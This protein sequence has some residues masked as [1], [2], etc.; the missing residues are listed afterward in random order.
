MELDIV[1]PRKRP[2]WDVLLLRSG[3]SSFFHTA[4]WAGVLSDTYGYK[5]LYFA[6]FDGGR[7]SGLMAFMEIRSSLTGRRG[8]SLP[9]SDHCPAYFAS[10]DHFQEVANRALDY[11]RNAG[12]R[13]IEWR[14]GGSFPGT[15]P[16]N[17]LYLTHD[18]DL[19]RAE[20]ALLSQQR[21]NMRRNIR[22]AGREGVAISIDRSWASVRSFCRLNCLTRKRHGLP[23]QP[24][25]FFM[26]IFE[27]I[28]AKGMGVV[29]S[30]MHSGRL[31]AASVFFHFGDTALFKFGASD[32][33]YQ[34][35]RP[36]NLVMWEAIRWHKDQGMSRL[37][38]GRTDPQNDGLL[39]FKRAW[40]GQ[41]TPL[42]YHR[43]DFRKEAFLA[44]AG[45]TPLLIKRLFSRMP[46]PVLRMIGAL[47]Y[48]HAG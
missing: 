27:H 23:P 40:G 11:G 32:I 5:P 35:L 8:V 22:K 19:D 2:D 33:S 39:R 43:Y 26:N 28:I 41:E 30:A 31:I 6:Y 13:T 36:N 1:D 45:R 24:L 21:E 15:V 46:V 34:R 44:G 17:E 12:W 25:S 9:F 38:L 20:A 37:N 48:K 14:D 10:S 18:L 3:D 47:A 4:A 29:V 16:H 42:A 7:L